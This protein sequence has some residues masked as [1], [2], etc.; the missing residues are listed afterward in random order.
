[1][2]QRKKA[3][4]DGSVYQDKNGQWWAKVPLLDGSNGFRRARA[5]SAKEAEQK[6][7][8]LVAQRDSG[9]NLRESRQTVSQWLD[10]F[11]IAKK[12]AVASGTLTFYRRHAGYAAAYI[13]HLSLEALE[14]RHL[15]EILPKLKADGLAPRSVRH[16]RTVLG[17]ALEMA[18]KDGIVG[19][20]VARLVDPP[21]AKQ[22]AA[23][24]MTDN[25]IAALVRAMEGERLRGAVLL[26]LELG[27]RKAE[28]LALRWI[29][30]DLDACDARGNPRPVLRV[31]DSKTEA[32]VRTLPLMPSVVDLL[33]EQWRLLQE[34]RQLPHWKEHGYVFP[35]TK[36]TQQGHRRLI[37]WFKRML[38]AAELP[39]RIRVH[40]LRHTA[41]TRW[42]AAG[43]P[44]GVMQAMAGHA[45]VSTTLGIYTHGK[46]EQMR[47]ALEAV[48]DK[49]KVG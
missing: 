49:K 20:N 11:L 41:I 26:M 8:E 42:D 1:M 39:E 14:P 25:E 5:A 15:R 10:H 44:A 28:T 36:G 35:S 4:G 9:T 16:V 47:A 38:R 22:Y 23:Y 33:R 32:G 46:L 19:R 40:D 17:T 18:V 24:A 6:R 37:E 3:R 12:E 48:E 31:A 30:V 7:R 27:L 45:S 2:A 13:G 29:D 43:M 34:L 21:Q